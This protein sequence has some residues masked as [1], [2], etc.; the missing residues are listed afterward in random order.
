VRDVNFF[1]RT[2][3]VAHTINEV[4]GAW[5]EGDGKTAS[6]RRTIALPQIRR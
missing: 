3:T 4:D 2:L 6:S 1:A 5:I